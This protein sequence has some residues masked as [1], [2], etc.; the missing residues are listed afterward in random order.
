M[1]VCLSVCLC[2][3]FFVRECVVGVCVCVCFCVWVCVGAFMPAPLGC[4]KGRMSALICPRRYLESVLVLVCV[5]VTLPRGDIVRWKPSSSGLVYSY[6]HKV[7]LGVL[8]EKAPGQAR[9]STASRACT[10]RVRRKPS[11]L[12]RGT[13]ALYL[14]QRG[15]G[16]KQP[17]L[18]RTGSSSTPPRIHDQQRPSRTGP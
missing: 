4:R 12:S 13:F 7:F 8:S 5:M 14:H 1:Y 16:L 15:H 6:P 9:R 17:S 10:D 11:V 3:P 18:P 2:M